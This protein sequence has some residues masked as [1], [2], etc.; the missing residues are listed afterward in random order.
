MSPIRFIVAGIYITG[1]A[2]IFS[3]GMMLSGIG[4]DNLAMCRTGIYLCFLFYVCGNKVLIYLFMV[5][6]KNLFLL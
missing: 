2:L 4:L 1:M 5:S 3:L 6:S